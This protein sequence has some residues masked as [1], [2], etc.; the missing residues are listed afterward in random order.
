MIALFFEVLPRPG[1]ASA[2]FQKAAA[3]KPALDANGGL[4][5]LDRSTSA[6]RPG[7]F[8]SH[9]FWTCDEA[10]ER[11]RADGVGD[12]QRSGAQRGTVHRLDRSTIGSDTSFK[13]V[14]TRQDQRS[15]AIVNQTT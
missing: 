13:G 9:Q 14:R 4:L 11:W 3:L 15:K 5:F 6:L 12:S 8:L 2:Y 10:M 7:W 1:Q